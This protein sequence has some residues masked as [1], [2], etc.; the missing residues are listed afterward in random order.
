MEEKNPIQ[1]A[2]RLFQTIEILAAKGP[3]GL[4]ELSKTLGLNKSTMHRILNSLTYMGYVQQD[5]ATSKYQL[6]FRIC[7]ISSQI[8]ARLDIIAAAKPYLQ[9][10][11][12]AAGETVHLV[13]IDGASAVYIDKF[14]SDQNSVRMVSK[15]GEVI[16]LYRSGVGKA[17][18]AVMPPEKVRRIW[19][20]SDIKAVTEK[21]IT[22]LDKLEQVLSQARADGY[23]MD[24]EEN[25]IGVRCIAAALK[26]SS[27]TA[28][29]AFSISAPAGRMDERRVRELSV[30]VLNTQKE[31]EKVLQH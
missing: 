3:Q 11:C 5:S 7:R 26:D 8:L 19:T 24:N 12:T 6:T 9:A 22:S 14:E 15:V 30:L 27:G 25:E 1:V 18:L 4:L 29:Y 2:D 10:L 20:Q 17:L 31:I 21:T 16:P 28:S 23:A 13:K